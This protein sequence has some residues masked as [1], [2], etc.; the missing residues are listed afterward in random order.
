MCSSPPY[1]H[2]LNNRR[3]APQYTCSGFTLVEMLISLAIFAIILVPLIAFLSSSVREQQVIRDLTE[4][5]QTKEIALLLLR[6]DLRLAGY[7]DVSNPGSAPTPTLAASANSVA[8]RGDVISVQFYDDRPGGTDANITVEYKVDSSEGSNEL[9]LKR[10]LT[11]LA[12]GNDSGFQPVVE[13]VTK[14]ELVEVVAVDAAAGT[15][16]T[17]ERGPNYSTA[18]SLISAAGLENIVRITLE[19]TFANG[20]TERVSV[21]FVNAQQS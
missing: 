10:K 2:R 17:Y 16:S 7:T 15:S 20:D 1:N 11:N 6:G 14:L 8:I 3:P 4:E 21:A 5:Q 12:T 9:N 19:L 13:G 18:S